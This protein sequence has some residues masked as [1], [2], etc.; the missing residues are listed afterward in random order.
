[1]IFHKIILYSINFFTLENEHKIPIN[2]NSWKTVDSQ[3]N[4]KYIKKNKQNINL[5]KKE[6]KLKMFSAALNTRRK[7]SSSF[8]LPIKMY[9]KVACRHEK[10]WLW[11]E[12][13]HLWQCYQNGSL[14]PLL[15]LLRSWNKMLLDMNS[16]WCNYYT[17]AMIL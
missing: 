7:K 4:I 13:N 3:L 16:T 14:F 2:L 6:P 15:N 10:S 9:Q 11:T 1:M 8:V 12:I 17:L 5:N